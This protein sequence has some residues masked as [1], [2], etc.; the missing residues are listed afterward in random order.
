MT[1]LPE[2]MPESEAP[3]PGREPASLPFDH[4][5]SPRR[6]SGP[7]RIT[8]RGIRMTLTDFD[9]E[10]DPWL[11]VPVSDGSQVLFGFAT[12]HVETGGLAWT[13]SSPIRQSDARTRRPITASGRRYLLG[14]RIGCLDLPD[15]EA[16]CAFA[17]LI[18]PDLG[19]SFSDLVGPEVRQH[20]AADWLRACKMA[21]HLGL[22]PPPL[23]AAKVAVFI[24]QN[25]EAYRQV[26]GWA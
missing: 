10:L 26:R 1:D 7:P 21:R 24:H 12:A 14:R 16:R 4:E 2:H 3:R 11:S 25:E 18:G 22:H 9:A 20:E 19:L 23:Q 15:L 6:R 13:R 17:L 8:C 5:V